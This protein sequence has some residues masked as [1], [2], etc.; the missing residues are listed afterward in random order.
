MRLR[1]DDG[2]QANRCFS[3][4]HVTDRKWDECWVTDGSS[5]SRLLSPRWR[6]AEQKQNTQR[7][8]KRILGREAGRAALQLYL[9]KSPAALIWAGGISPN[10][11]RS[12]KSDGIAERLWSL[13]SC[14]KHLMRTWGLNLT[15][16]SP[17]QDLLR[18]IRS[19][20]P[21][22]PVDDTV[23]ASRVCLDLLSYETV[24]NC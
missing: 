18:Q 15:S 4:S 23:T 16:R 8:Q 20:P 19:P 5:G 10:I 9:I 13:P 17:H 1:R 6:Q 2:M 12:W 7:R 3:K 24:S 21:P 11:L 22:D 14:S